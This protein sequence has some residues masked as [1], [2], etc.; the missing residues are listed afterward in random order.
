M[1]RTFYLIKTIFIFLLLFF[2]YQTLISNNF[3]YM[4]FINSFSFSRSIPAL[5]F[6]FLLL[7]T[8]T[9]VISPF[10]K[11][12]ASLFLIFVVF[13]NVA[14]YCSMGGD[15]RIVLWSI[16]CIPITLII[17]NFFPKI[18]FI[19]LKDKQVSILLWSLLVICLIPVLLAHGVRFNLSVFYLDV[20]DVR[21]ESRLSNTMLSVYGYFWLA[22]VICPIGLVYAIERKKILMVITFI[23]VLFYLF[24]TTGHKSVFFTVI[25]IFVMYKG[26]ED[27]IKKNNYLLNGAILLFCISIILTQVFNVITFESL[28][29]RRLLF[30]P[31]LLNTYYFDFFNGKFVYYSSSYFSMFL[32]YPYDRPIPEVIGLNY[33]NSEEMSANNGYISDGFANLGDIGVF[34]NIIMGALILKIFKDYNVSPKYAGLIFVLFYAIQGSAM[35]TVLL[36]HGG[37]LMLFLVPMVLRRNNV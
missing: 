10:S 14:L 32:D 27:F 21:R 13:P 17:F 30:I 6:T 25:L 4:G 20:Y 8:L 34:I 19:V 1:H 18:K 7:V 5:F 33:Y 23:C 16:L 24:M 36:T 12:V 11:F 35:S 3:S 28:F 26:G 37:I 22:K 15:W 9:F 2:S 31:A 29:I